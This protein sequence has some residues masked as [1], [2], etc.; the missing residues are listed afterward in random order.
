MLSTHRLLAS[1]ISLLV[2]LPIGTA[3][4]QD[5]ITP[6]PSLRLPRSDNTG[7]SHEN[8]LFVEQ[9]LG[10]ANA[11]IEAGRFAALQAQAEAVRHLARQIAAEQQAIKDE[12]SRLSRAKGYQPTGN[13]PDE[14]ATLQRLPGTTGEA[15][16]DQR[17]LNAQYHASRWLIAAYQNEMAATQDL[18]LRTFA[19]TRVLTLRQQL[20][21][22]QKVGNSVGLRLGAPSNPPQY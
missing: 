3:L 9:A 7:L 1:A 20:D 6:S 18:D 2:S 5:N 10:G 15:E 4:S 8:R 14:L 21:A 12:L 16:I 11:A 22:F 13:V 17:Y 19:G